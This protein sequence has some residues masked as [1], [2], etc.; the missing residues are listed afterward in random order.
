[1]IKYIV[2]T[3]LAS[4]ACLCAHAVTLNPHG[5][6]QVL[7]YPY[8]TVENGQ[9]T[10]ISVVNTSEQ[11]KRVYVQVREGRNSRLVAW[12]DVYLSA[13]DAWTAAITSTADGAKIVTA[14]ASCTRPAIPAEGLPLSSDAYTGHSIAP[15]NAPDSG[16]QTL[17][18][19][20]EGHIDIVTKYE[21]PQDSDAYRAIAPAV[22]G[23]PP[24]DCNAVAINDVSE[25]VPSDTLFG[26][27]AIVNVGEGTFFGYGADALAGF[28]ATALFF[29]SSATAEIEILGAANS[30]SSSLT[31]TAHVV[32]DDG[33]PLSIDY[34]RGI[35]AVSAVFMVDSALNEY[36][37][38]SALGAA[39]DW[40]VAFPTKRFYTDAQAYPGAP[41]APFPSAFAAGRADVRVDA[42]FH[43]QEGGAAASILPPN[44]GTSCATNLAPLSYAVNVLSILHAGTDGRSPVLGS[45]LASVLK[46]YT[47]AASLNDAGWISMDFDS[48]AERH[49]LPDGHAGDHTVTLHGL[50]ASGFMVYNIINA[51]AAPGRLANYGGA[52]THRTGVACSGMGVATCP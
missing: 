41:R 14:D 7:I 43:D 2:A 12:L 11:G 29:G 50:P 9:D 24:R 45:Q 27:A 17:D 36:L 52:F 49:T 25:V 44:C 33:E 34:T 4:T 10:L 16:P 3:A 32:G 28:T 51:N 47:M 18:R 6:G 38:A 23:G 20:R 15:Y 30:A 37:T 48:D 39:T 42:T 26:S 35:D 21:F 46:P 22:P 13:H 19:V 40:V 8:Y 31:A 1:M 5:R